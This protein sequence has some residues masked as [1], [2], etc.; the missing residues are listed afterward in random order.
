MFTLWH[1]FARA[2]H[3]VGA[4]FEDEKEKDSKKKQYM[5]MA[6]DLARQAVAIDDQCSS[7]HRWVGILIQCAGDFKSTKEQI[8]ES[9][10]TKDAWEAAVRINPKDASAMNLIGRCE[11]LIL[12]VRDR[13]AW[14]NVLNLV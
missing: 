9:Y 14:L 2:A 8:A 3:D 4:E 10:L 5:F 13:I 7:A 11:Y 12:S 6:L 1:R